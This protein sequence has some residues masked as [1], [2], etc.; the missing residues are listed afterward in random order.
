MSSSALKPIDNRFLFV[1]LTSLYF[2]QGFPSGLLAHAMPAIMREYGASHSAIGALKLLALPWLFK[3]LWAPFIDRFY[4]AS[5]SPHRSWILMMQCGA[6]ATL[7]GLSLMPADWIFGQGLAVLFV[8]LCLLNVF[9]STQDVATDGLAVSLLSEKLRGLG[10]TVQVAGYKIGLMLG[11]SG[12]LIMM[13]SIGWSLTIQLVAVTLILMLIPTLFFK[14]NSVLNREERIS[15]RS[16]GETDSYFFWDYFKI[17]HIAYWL[18]VLFTYKLADGMSSTLVK[19]M[20]I[21]QGM[22]L[23]RVGEITLFSS[24]AGLLGA[25]L[26]GV[27]YRYFKPLQL[28]F[29]FA[30]LQIGSISAYALIPGLQVTNHSDVFWMYWIVTQDQLVDTMSTVVLF[31]IMMGHCRKT[32]EGGDY[33]LQACVQVLSAGIAGA[34]GGMIADVLNN[35]VWSFLFAASLGVLALISLGVYFSKPKSSGLMTAAN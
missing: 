20:L 33:T 15:G 16:S 21:D 23:A 22:D 24:I 27:I 30:V 5:L 31:A 11:G 3:F 35:Y 1:L 25:V 34:L 6:V 19:S 7:L 10:N 2:S 32:H 28:L 26:V 9:S 13:N 8:L 12:L 4:Y 14:E 18:L 29:G 17:K